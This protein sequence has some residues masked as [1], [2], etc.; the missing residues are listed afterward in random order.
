[1]KGAV[2]NAINCKLIFGIKANRAGDLRA[3]VPGDFASLN[4]H[5][6]SACDEPSVLKT[7]V[8]RSFLDCAFISFV[9]RAVLYYGE[10]DFLPG[11]F[12]L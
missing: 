5:G 1:M 4:P 7:G 3:G 10:T 2:K 8:L 11:Y 9:V 6:R 12:L